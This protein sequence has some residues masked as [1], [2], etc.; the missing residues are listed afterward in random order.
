M[1]ASSPR[2]S[3]SSASTCRS[4][5]RWTS[6]SEMLAAVFER[7]R[8]RHHRGEPPG[9]HPRQPADGALEQV[10]LARAHDRQQV[11]ELRRLLDALRRLRRRLRGH[12][13]RPKT[14]VYRLVDFRN[15]RDQDHPVPRSIVERPPSAELRPDQKDADS[16]P[17]YDTLD[18]ILAAYVEEDAGRDQ[19]DAGRPARRS[20]R[21]RRRARRPG[22]VQAPPGAAGDQDHAAG[23]RPRPAHADH[24]RLP[25]R[26]TA[27]PRPAR[28]A[29][30]ASR[31]AGSGRG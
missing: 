6:T 12:Q 15:G 2:A 10:R 18:A 13:G 5:R 23:V 4:R 3:G 7:P 30:R 16:L 25:R 24:Q 11:G 8:A 22:R 14:L 29:P 20:R 26:L 28:A 27:A 19:L 9:A 31:R 1:R 21:A 17:D